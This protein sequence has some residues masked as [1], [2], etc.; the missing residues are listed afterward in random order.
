MIGPAGVD[1][2]DLNPCTNGILNAG[3][4]KEFT[5]SGIDRD[6]S[7]YSHTRIRGEPKR[8]NGHDHR[9][10]LWP[11]S[12]TAGMTA[13]GHP[14]PAWHKITYGWPAQHLPLATA[15]GMGPDL[16]GNFPP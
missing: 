10:H 1:S 8:L 16:A 12:R 6:T 4:L 7:R 3:D 11:Y 14:R 13:W 2:L 9:C 15:T 5:L